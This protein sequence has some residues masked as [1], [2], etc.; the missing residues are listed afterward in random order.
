MTLHVV[1]MTT[2]R[3]VFLVVV[4]AMAV[5]EDDSCAVSTDVALLLRWTTY[6]YCYKLERY[7]GRDDQGNCN[8]IYAHLGRDL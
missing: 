6:Q 1:G 7:G 3:S 4:F 5:Y 8:S 2:R